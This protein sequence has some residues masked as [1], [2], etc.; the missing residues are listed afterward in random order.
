MLLFE[1]ARCAERERGWPARS[2]KIVLQLALERLARHYG[3]APSTSG[4]RSLAGAY[5]AC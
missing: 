5:L 1:K 2:A 3:Y 4:L